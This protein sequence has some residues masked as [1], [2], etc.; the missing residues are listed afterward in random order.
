MSDSDVRDEYAALHA[1]AGRLLTQ[2]EAFDLERLPEALRVKLLE[3]R[4]YLEALFE[5][6]DPGGVPFLESVFRSLG[7]PLPIEE[8]WAVVRQSL[9]AARLAAA[10]S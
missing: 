6:T 4:A 3:D 10:P 2:L 1:H 7:R 8:L 5:A 9:T